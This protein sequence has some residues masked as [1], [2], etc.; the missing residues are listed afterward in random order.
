M[1]DHPK[2][3]LLSLADL[4]PEL[5]HLLVRAV[6]M[7]AARRKGDLSSVRPGRN[8]GMIFEKPSTR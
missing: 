4:G 8:L 6:E 3:D 7:K 1:S 2:R 5:P